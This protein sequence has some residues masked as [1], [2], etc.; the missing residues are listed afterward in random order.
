MRRLINEEENIGILT[1]TNYGG[2][3]I[4]IVD[5]ENIEYQYDFGE[6]SLS[7][8]KRTKLYFRDDNDSDCSVF[9]KT[10]ENEEYS[11]DEFMR[12]NI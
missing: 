2:I 8:V 3:V 10:D 4:K 12:R 1:L 5:D 11:L 6:D 9:F 7:E